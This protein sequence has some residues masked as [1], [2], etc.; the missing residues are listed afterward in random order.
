MPRALAR[1][2]ADLTPATAPRFRK[3]RCKSACCD[4]TLSVAAVARVAAAAVPAAGVAAATCVSSEQA[5]DRRV[6]SDTT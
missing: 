1:D 5:K 4:A 3:R 6:G 2:A